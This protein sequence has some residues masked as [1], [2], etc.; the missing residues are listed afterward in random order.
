MYEL[1]SIITVYKFIFNRT[2]CCC[3]ICSVVK[4]QTLLKYALISGNVNKEGSLSVMSFYS[5][6]NMKNERSEKEMTLLQT[7]FP[8]IIRNY[9]FIKQNQ[10]IQYSCRIC[11]ST[12]ILEFVLKR[13]SGKQA[14][15]LTAV[16]FNVKLLNT[17]AKIN[18]AWCLNAYF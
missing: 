12:I 4:I 17:S 18:S 5:I 1:N 16:S 11:R 2:Y 14:I 15:R 10:F 13:D 8:Q 7:F 3:N 6:S 9:I